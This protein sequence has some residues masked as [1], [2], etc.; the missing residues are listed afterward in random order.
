MLTDMTKTFSVFNTRARDQFLILSLKC[1]LGTCP[2]INSILNLFK[3]VL[4]CW[5]FCLFASQVLTSSACLPKCIWIKK[6]LISH[7]SW[8]KLNS[9]SRAICDNDCSPTRGIAFWGLTAD[10]VSVIQIISLNVVRAT[11]TQG[12]IRTPICWQSNFKLNTLCCKFY[13]F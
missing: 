1:S 2:L 13:Y 10:S 4:H 3:I 8:L 9:I 11:L 7:F 5:L 12:F 6:E